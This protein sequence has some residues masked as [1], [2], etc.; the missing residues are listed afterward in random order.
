MKNQ[1]DIA[2]TVVEMDSVNMVLN[3]ITESV[4]VV[5]IVFM[6]FRDKHVKNAIH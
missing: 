2:K 3:I 4:M 1:K 5:V 6:M